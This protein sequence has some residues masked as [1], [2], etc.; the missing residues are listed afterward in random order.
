MHALFYYPLF[1]P[2]L[3]PYLFPDVTARRLGSA[4]GE[5]IRGTVVG[6]Q[7]NG[8]RFRRS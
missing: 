7:Y 5:R 1:H 8:A 4:V 3:H 2:G 6:I